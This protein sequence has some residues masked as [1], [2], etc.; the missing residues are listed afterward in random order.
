M[1]EKDNILTLGSVLFVITALV[2]LLLA[3]VNMLTAGKIED[4]AQKEQVEARLA[5]L[6]EAEE[7]IEVVYQPGE[8]SA[9][10]QIFEGKKGGQR[11]GYCV[12]VTPNGFGGIIDMMVGIRADGTVEAVKIVSMSETPGLGSK[13]TDSSFIGQFAGKETK[14]PIQVI[15]SGTAQSDEIVAIA[16]AT[17]TSRGVTEGVNEAIAAV[18][19]LEGGA[20]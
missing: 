5:V 14:S 4:N 18:N 20:S 9:V 15:K 1:R 16:G 8:G 12:S 3:S 6:Q 13:A 7:F 10:Q 2:A 19:A 11:V 17:V